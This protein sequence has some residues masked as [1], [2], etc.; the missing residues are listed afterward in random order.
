[1]KLQPLTRTLATLAL[2]A[3]AGWA[4]AQTMKPGLWE[5]TTQMQSGSGKMNDAMA[6][7]QKALEGMT[8]DQRKM[9]Q[10]MMAKQG[11]QMGGPAAGGGM[12][13]KV[14]MTQEMVDRNEVGT[15][16]GD[17]THTNSQR[18][19]NTMKFS[20]VCTQ[21]PSSGEGQVTFNSPESYAVSMT[22]STT[23]RGNAEKMAMQSNGRW[24]GSDCGGIK[25][26]AVPK[27]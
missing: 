2:I 13:V 23:V 24:L 26:L 3:T 1:M 27:K 14:C 4:Q 11:V 20:F 9:M 12:A 6:Q 19:G 25:P 15:Q 8:P 5:I 18:T 22:S 21:P 16:K 10:D 7:A 17:C